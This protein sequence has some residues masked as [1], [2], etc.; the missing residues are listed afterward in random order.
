LLVAWADT[1]NEDVDFA[2]EEGDGWVALL[3]WRL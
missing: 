1:S 2:N 3:T